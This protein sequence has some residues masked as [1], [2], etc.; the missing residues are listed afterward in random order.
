[1]ATKTLVTLICDL[2]DAEGDVETHAIAVDRKDRELE[3]C[4]SC[5]AKIEKATMQA[6]VNGRT[7]TKGSRRRRSAS[8]EPT[9]TVNGAPSSKVVRAWA[10]ANGVECPSRGRVP[11]SVLEQYAAAH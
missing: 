7:V 3:A 6:L 10:E 11:E 1:M 9:P 2:C 4:P 5:W 8:S